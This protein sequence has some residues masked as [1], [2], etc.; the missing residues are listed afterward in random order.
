M[1]FPKLPSNY[2]NSKQWSFQE[3]ISCPESTIIECYLLFEATIIDRLH[4]GYL[5][6][7]DVF[8]AWFQICAFSLVDKNNS[9]VILYNQCLRAEACNELSESLTYGKKAATVASSCCS[10]FICNQS[11]DWFSVQF[12]GRPCYASP[13]D[14]C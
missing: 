3:C 12:Q 7:H 11:K 10:Y 9:R 4:L 13:S 1:L 6:F 5:F 14:W 2:L 8:G